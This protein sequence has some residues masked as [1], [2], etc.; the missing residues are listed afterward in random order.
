MHDIYCV[1][2]IL[3]LRKTKLFHNNDYYGMINKKESVRRSLFI[4]LREP[5]QEKRLRSA[6]AGE[7]NMSK[8]VDENRN[9]QNLSDIEL[10][11]VTGGDASTVT[12]SRVCKNCRRATIH[13]VY[14]GGRYVCSV[15]NTKS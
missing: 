15:C 9:K 7:T 3:L 10:E 6:Y 12:T 14:S 4:T 11:H 8:T 1:T 13:Y 5:W 2:T